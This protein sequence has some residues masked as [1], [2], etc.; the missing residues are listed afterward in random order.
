V[1]EHQKIML[2]L[3]DEIERK[4]QYYFNIEQNI[5]DV[6]TAVCRYMGGLFST[7]KIDPGYTVGLNHERIDIFFET[8]DQT[9]AFSV[10]KPIRP[11]GW[12][13]APK[14]ISHPTNPQI[15]ALDGDTIQTLHE[16]LVNHQETLG[17]DFQKVLYD[18]LWDL[19]EDTT[20]QP[21][22]LQDKIKQGL[23]ARLKQRL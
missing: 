18:N 21:P 3:K 22:T 13:P 12:K 8:L 2:A 19:Y 9:A 5:N 11:T 15:A 7:Y 14:L 10:L 16:Y 6:Y 17:L 23:A 1:N 4:V 20:P